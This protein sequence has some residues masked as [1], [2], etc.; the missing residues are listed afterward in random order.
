VVGNILD[1]GTLIYD[2]SDTVTVSVVISGS[3][4]LTKT[5]AGTLIL[6]GVNTVSGLTTVSAGMLEV[7]DAAHP[8]AVLDSHIG[9]VVV[10]SGATLSG[11][12]T[13]NGHVTNSAGGTVSPGGT[14]GTLTVASYTQGPSGNLA[15]EVSP[16]VASKLNALGAASLNGHLALS[17]DAGAYG[18]AVYTIVA[19]APVTGTFSS[20]TS[21]GSP[22]TGFVDGLA[23]TSTAVDLVVMPTAPAQVFGGIS[24]ATLD[25]ANG[26]TS[27]VE[28]RFGDAGCADG[29]ADKA[30]Q[31]CRAG[32]WAQVIATNDRISTTASGLGFNNT[33]TGFIG[34]VDGRWDNGVTAGAAFGYEGDNL[35]MSGASAKATGSNYYGAVYGRWVMGSAWLD[36]QAF[37]MHSDWTLN[38]QLSGFGTGRS[39][40]SGD[41]KGVQIQ[42]S[43]PITADLRPYGRVS[44]AQFDRAAVNETGLG[45]GDLAI[46][47]ASDSVGTAEVGVA[48][49]HS[50]ASGGS[51]WRP[52]LQVGVQ[53]VFGDRSP[54]V[55]GVLVGIPGTG[56][57]VNSARVAQVAGVVDG[58]IKVQINQRF[59]LTA[60][61]RGRFSNV[62]ADTSASIG[63]VFHF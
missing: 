22:G 48:F 27:L 26:L 35:T 50:Y 47:S 17:F 51:V 62:Q 43:A 10:G 29:T 9:G 53:D 30:D 40:P 25:R 23:Y 39:N 41:T 49:A 5:G 32:A 38:R 7:G 13:I 19:G 46:G 11:H 63:G 55:T 33:S 59:E 54:Q 58:A 24:T 57:T 60:D 20:V 14:I 2:H 52:S 21:T 42:I 3:G 45:F 4:A 56:F 28:D 34:G 18:P 8:G 12:G 1:N 6:D 37:Y 31:T 44:W 61:L 15:I 16:A 36:G